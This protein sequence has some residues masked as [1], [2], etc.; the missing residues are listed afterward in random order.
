MKNTTSL[1]SHVT[2]LAVVLLLVWLIPPVTA[3]SSGTSALGGT[4]TDPS[5]AAI[6]NVTV[7]LT[8]NGTGQTRTGTTGSDGTYKFT[9]LPPGDYKVR[10]VA[11]GFKTAEVA[12][13][14]L[15]VTETPAL[16]RT[17]EVGAQTEQITVEAA[18]E[19][20]QTQSSTLGT[21][22]SSQSI[23]DQPL[24]SRNYTQILNMEAGAASGVNDATALGKGTL[25]MSVNGAMPEQNNWQMD[26]VSVVNSFGT[27][28]ARDCG[29]YVGIAIPSPDAIQEFK[30]QTS[31]YD[32]S[33]GRNPGANV[34]VV[35]KSGSNSF[36]GTLFEF[37]RNEDL[38]A[39]GF[40][41]NAEGTGKQIL[42]QN[43][44]GG[45]FG[46][47][48]K[49]DK[50]FFF[51]SYQGTRQ[52]NGVSS[53]GSSSVFL[54]PIPAGD[55]STPAFQAA[56]GA[57]NCAANHPGD[58]NFSTFASA[59]GGLQI[60]CDGS[61]ISPVALAILNAKNPNGSYYMVGSPTG[62]YEQ[63]T[64]SIPAKYTGDQYIANVDYLL[65]SK[66]TIAMRY[67]FSEDP[68]QV[69]FGSGVPG[70]PIFSYYANT[71]AVLK[72][73]TLL[74]NSLVN[75]AHAT[76]QRN[77]A[78]GHDATPQYTPQSAGITPIVPQQTQPPVM[79][80][81]NTYGIGGT[82]APYVGPATQ[83]NFGDQVSWSHG[84]HTFRFGGEFEDDQWNLS[85]K[86]LLRGFLFIPGFDDFLLGRPGL[87]GCDVA[88]GCGPANPGNTTGAPVGTYLS[89]LFCVR[90]GPNGIIHGYRERDVA[91]FA[92]DDWKV[93]PRL[94]LNLGVRW[95]RDGMLADHYGNL[96][97]IWPSLLQTMPIPPTTPQTGAGLVGYVVPNNFE[98]HYGTPPPGVKVLNS[99]SPTDGGIPWD[100]FGPRF[101]FAL[102]PR[103][104]G[105]LVVR[106]GVGLFYD[107][108]GSSKFVHA[109]EQGDPYAVTLDVASPFAA[110]PYSLANPFPSTPLGFTPRYYN[111]AYAA[112]CGNQLALC[113][114]DLNQPFY[115][116]IHTPLTR[117][118]NL[119]IQYEFAPQWVL[120]VGYV[121]SSGINQADYNHN[122]NT[123]ILASANNPVNGLT[124]TTTANV[125]ARVPYLGYDPAG[126]QGTG[127]DGIY[128]YNSLQLTVRKHFSHGV[129]MQAAYT[130]SKT[131]TTLNGDSQANSNNASNL[132]QQY[133]PAYYEHPQ[134]FIV[135]Y[136]YEIPFG[137][138]GNAFLKKAAEGWSMTGNIVVQDGSPLTFTNTAGGSAYGTGSAGTGEGGSARAQLCPGVTYNMLQTS[139]S[140]TS[141]LGGSNSAN[142]YINVNDFCA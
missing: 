126:L 66:N 25:D 4:V 108:V 38:D 102:Q 136:S 69:P 18:T 59:F 22:V 94:T 106:G 27:G 19:V 95:E 135:S 138:P 67:L 100:N 33:Y 12:S 50:L 74:T 3:Q 30:V 122:Y 34:N 80:I 103:K 129:T 14:A 92:Q 15:A 121:G 110:A 71:N 85:F 116:V 105:K 83:V 39:N 75:E 44:F 109:V 76:V 88:G 86:S 35:T 36:H 24:A 127:Y 123:A 58:P 84:K 87:A 41:E 40:F 13:I 72:L 26:G 21:V 28:V 65:N 1:R 133:G 131:L 37:F 29:I 48:I 120:E 70:T 79:V 115:S 23:N 61:N 51:G 114:S 113:T 117:Q 124:T 101:G 142:G 56:L 81:L 64:F 31:T 98:S 53:A 55:R 8:N 104:D 11:N 73:T 5:G 91:G 134:R 16:D 137:N 52:L 78:N 68:Q 9:L 57:E 17:L 132:G 112:N 63:T 45:T 32:A 125:D 118:Y 90:S 6:P 97:N 89:C 42:R 49:K 111:P 77:I 93:S 130:W 46:G 119:G 99:S 2:A 62:N 141:R 60:A 82:L 107:R 20:L 10:F 43:Q 47:P 128:N 140:I 139:G 96:T 54:P 7:T